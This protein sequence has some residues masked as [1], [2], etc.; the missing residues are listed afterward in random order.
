MLRPDRTVPCVYL[1]RA[2]VD[3]RKQQAGLAALVQEG[4]SESPFSGALFA[5]TNKRRNK[6]KLLYWEKNGFVLW[7]KS[8]SQEQFH[9]PRHVD[10]AVVTLSGEQL[11][12]LLDGYDVWKMKPHN[13]LQ[14]S[15]VS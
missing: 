2:P 13:A 6:L 14:F 7:Y 11:N 8:L 3:L 10:E 5:F 12:W 15:Q 4:M 9:W 1:H